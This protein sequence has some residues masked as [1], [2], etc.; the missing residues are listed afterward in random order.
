MPPDRCTRRSRRP[1]RGG[2]R[3]KLEFHYTPKHGSWLNV[4]KCELAVLASQSLA[5]R[6]ATIDTARHEIAAWERQGNAERPTVRWHFTT[7]QARRK[8]EILYPSDATL[9]PSPT[10]GRMD[11]S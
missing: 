6:F 11:R 5:R 3:R 8:L 7:S 1:R 2:S 9:S 4:A 10:G